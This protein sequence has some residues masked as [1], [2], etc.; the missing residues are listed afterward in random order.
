MVL[1]INAM[2]VT[3]GEEN[4]AYTSGS[5][6]YRFLSPVYTY[7]CNIKP[8]IHRAITCSSIK[9]VY[10]AFPWTQATVLKNHTVVNAI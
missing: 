10:V 3:S 4:I 9:S 2:K 1:A 8:C 5:A 6:D 7:R